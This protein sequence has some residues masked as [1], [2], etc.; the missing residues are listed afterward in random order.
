MGQAVKEGRAAAAMYEEP[1]L[2]LIASQDCANLRVV[3]SIF[4][5][6]EYGYVFPKGSLLAEHVSAAI[7]HM[8][9]EGIHE[10]LHPKYFRSSSQGQGDK[11]AS[12]SSAEVN[13]G[14]IGIEAV[15]GP[16][17]LFGGFFALLTFYM[18]VRAHIRN[19]SRRRH[20]EK[21][22]EEADDDD[23]DDD[24]DDGYSQRKKRWEAEVES[25]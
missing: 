24:D 1:I 7:T 5:P 16:L 2:E 11:C 3:G 8:R 23:D 22:E 9:M 25:E 10:E 4:G 6:Q 15:L 14:Q 18:C 19:R 21:N 17:V 12:S 20:E 13:A